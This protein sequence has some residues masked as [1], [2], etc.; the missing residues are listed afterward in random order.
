MGVSRAVRRAVDIRRGDDSAYENQ[1][2]PDG[3]SA[4]ELR[5]VNRSRTP[6]KEFDDKGMAYV[7]VK[8][9]TPEKQAKSNETGKVE[10][11]ATVTYVESMNYKTTRHSIP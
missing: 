3:V 7:M 9:V 5:F 4:R 11:V 2:W 10:G 1:L 8:D 6:E